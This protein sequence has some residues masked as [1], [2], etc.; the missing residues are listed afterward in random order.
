MTSLTNNTQPQKKIYSTLGALVHAEE[1]KNTSSVFSKQITLHEPAGI[2][3][4]KV[5]CP[6][7][8]GSDA[9]KQ[10]TGKVVVE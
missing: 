5:A 4:V 3:F 8:I 7:C 2:Y 1:V 10:W 6:D 9:E